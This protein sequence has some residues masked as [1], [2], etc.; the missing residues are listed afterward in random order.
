MLAQ[1][2]EI[3]AMAAAMVGLRGAAARRARTAAKHEHRRKRWDVITRDAARRVERI[4]TRDAR[5]MQA[6]M[7]R[8]RE[9]VSRLDHEAELMPSDTGSKVK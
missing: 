3:Q 1:L 4:V 7:E 8:V 9:H 2:G 6:R 5:E